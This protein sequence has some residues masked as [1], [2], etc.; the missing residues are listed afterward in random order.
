MV[1][2]NDFLFKIDRTIAYYSNEDFI[3][4]ISS[5]ENFDEFSKLIKSKKENEKQLLEEGIIFLE[6]KENKE[7][8]QINFL[9]KYKKY[10]KQTLNENVM[11]YFNNYYV[12]Y[13]FC[14]KWNMSAGE[15]E[16]KI[17]C[18]DKSLEEIFELLEKKYDEI[19]NKIKNK[20]ELTNEEKNF[21]ENYILNFAINGAIC[22]DSYNDVIE[23]FNLYPI[24]II[25]NL[26]NR[27]LY[28]IYIASKKISKINPLCELSF[29]TNTN[30]EGIEA[31]TLGI[32]IQSSDGRLGITINYM[33]IY[34]IN[35]ENKF[36]EH[37]FT[38][39]HEIG[40][41]KQTMVN[42]EKTKNFYNMENFLI[43]E[44]L[45]FYIEHHDKFHIEIDANIYAIDELKKEFGEDNPLVVKMCDRKLQA[46]LSQ[47][48]KNFTELEIEEYKKLIERKKQYK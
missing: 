25:D 8:F 10:I 1:Y 2:L 28:I 30:L 4:E 48:V 21:F 40:H 45:D 15:N 22:D 27:Q 35:S 43:A 34:S 26:K 13:C 7:N 39:L 31:D 23:Y 3:L 5:I 47:D 44:D 24:N 11:E 32:T 14:K 29:D 12:S 17:F 6:N 38:L 20:N 16:S 42:D 9:E 37:L 33:D 18:F 41:L 36:Y 46:I 19:L